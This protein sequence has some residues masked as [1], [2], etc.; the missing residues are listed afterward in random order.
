MVPCGIM[1]MAEAAAD[2]LHGSRTIGFEGGGVGNSI[3]C[4]YLL[5][6][7]VGMVSGP[8]AHLISVVKYNKYALR[9]VL[10]FYA[11]GGHIL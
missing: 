9:G 1:G 2:P 8:G 6:L 5:Y 10:G 7:R 3:V 11:R 4:I